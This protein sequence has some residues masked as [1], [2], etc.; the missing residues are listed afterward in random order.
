MAY[1]DKQNVLAA[2]LECAKLYEQ[3]LNNRNYLFIMGKPNQYFYIET[4]AQG[5]N[6]KHLMGI[7]T[8]NNISA[9]D[10]YDACLNGKFSLSDFTLKADGTSV[11]KSKISR[12]LMKIHKNARMYGEF[13]STSGMVLKSEKLIGHVSGCIGYEKDNS[14]FYIPNTLL[15]D[16]IKDKSS[17]RQVH[18]VVAVYAKSK[19][20]KLYSQNCYIATKSDVSKIPLKEI[21]WHNKEI[22]GKIDNCNLYFE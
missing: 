16:N 19:Y 18:Q 17:K 12:N 13:S 20:E 4:F 22:E 10:F 9:I 15:F 3:Y 11:Q 7:N 21:V 14:G 2:I 6:F 1:S 5:S 8:V